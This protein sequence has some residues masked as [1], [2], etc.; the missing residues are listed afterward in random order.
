[1]Q[2]LFWHFYGFIFLVLLG[3]GWAVEQLWQQWQPNQ[4]PVWLASY[5]KQLVHSLNQPSKQWPE[6]ID[7]TIAPIET[8]SISWQPEELTQLQ[9]GQV[10]KLFQ[11][12]AVYFYYLQQHQQQLWV[13]G[14][15]P[16]TE[17][18]SATT[19][20]N[21]LFFVLLAISLAFWLWPIARDIRH[22][23]QGL[24][25][26]NKHTT[27]NLTL[28]NHS[29][30]APIS[31]SVQQ[32]T[33]QIHNLLNLQQEMTQAV[34]HEL[35]TPIARLNFALEMAYQLPEQDRQMML[36][37]V[38]ELQQLVDE[39]LDYARLETAESPLNN[40]HINLT[41]LL[42]NLQEKLS[43]LPGAAISMQLTDDAIIYGDGH[44]LERAIQNIIVNA[45]RYAKQTISLSLL[46]IEHGWQIIVEDDGPGI[47]N[48]LH[49]QVL[50]PFY[51]QE[52][53]RNKQGGGFGLGL[54]I[55]KRIMQWH[56]GK[57]SISDSV[58]GGACFTLTLIHYKPE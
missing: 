26:F 9:Q 46:P 33:T 42:T 19:W 3:S 27:P 49:K 57:I 36:Q 5:E 40:Q 32:L 50:E 29:V 56:K 52:S 7:L 22:L 28:P 6:L 58:L 38:R 25:N 48:A 34:S 51:R 2:R 44:Y 20:F 17:N 47:P 53:S 14:P 39:I 13:I 55:V 23:Q 31:Q 1:M 35:R 45:K 43:P 41:E 30:M 12:D 18:N 16:L 15:L 4:L 8:K 10:I 11:A 54:A 24:Q 37:D 21:L